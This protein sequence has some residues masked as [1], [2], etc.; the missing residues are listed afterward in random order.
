M[1]SVAKSSASPPLSNCTRASILVRNPFGC[2]ASGKDYVTVNHLH[3]HPVSHS[4]PKPY[5]ST[6]CSRT[7]TQSSSLKT[8]EL[9]HTGYKPHSCD[10]CGKRFIIKGYLLQHM[11]S[12][13][14]VHLSK[15]HAR[16]ASQR[17]P[18]LRSGPKSHACG[19]CGKAF[20]PEGPLSVSKCAF[21]QA[22]KPLQCPVCGKWE[23]G[24]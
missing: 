15:Q 7:F 4:A 8:H 23:S 11:R 21:T 14:P 3:R 16:L 13:T 2:E 12:H 5:R 20:L 19:Q 24:G 10:V 6:V 17:R 22:R 9:I 18:A 1:T